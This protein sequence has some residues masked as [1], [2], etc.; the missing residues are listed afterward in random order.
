[1]CFND[2]L[3]TVYGIGDNH[4]Q[5]RYKF[6]NKLQNTFGNTI[7]FLSPDYHSAQ[8]AI[9]T[10]C[11][12]EQSLSSFMSDFE[13]EIIFKNAANYLRSSVINSY[14]EIENYPGHLQ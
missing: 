8:I 6:K 5:Y 12:Q 10:K 11:F 2:C 4:V 1:M 7:T 3:M 13:P 14:S 9:S